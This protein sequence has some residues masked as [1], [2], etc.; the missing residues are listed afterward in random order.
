MFFPGICLCVL[1]ESS[2][3][4]VAA[5]AAAR[6][7][8]FDEVV[9]TATRRETS[10]SE[11]PEAVSVVTSEQ[12]AGRQLALDAIADTVGGYVQ[13]TTPGQGAA[14]I[15]GLKGSALLHLVDGMRLNNAIF[16]NAPTQYFALLPTTAAERIEVVRG[17]PASLYGSDA[18]G[19][20]V[21]F[22]TRRPAFESADAGVRGELSAGYE[23]VD[24]ARRIAGTIDAG[25]TDWYLTVSAESLRAGNRT[26]GGGETVGPS[27]WEARAGR[28]AAGL[29]PDDETTWSVDFH[30]YEQPNTPRVDELVPGSGQEDPSSSEFFFAPNRRVYGKA[31]Y[32]KSNGLAGVDWDVS[33][34]WQHIDDDRVT[35]DF[36]APDRRREQNSSDLYGLLVTA[37]GASETASW[38]AG[39]EL[40]YDLVTSARQ[41][42]NV[43][44]GA[45]APVTSRFPDGSEVLRGS[46]FAS[47]E[48]FVGER[49]TLSGGLRFSEVDVRLPATPVTAATT[50][51]NGDLAGDL[52]AIVDLISGWQWTANLGA[53]FRAPNVFDLGTLGSRPGNRFNVPNTFL[54]SEQV[55]QFDTGLRYL[56]DRLQFEGVVY[57]LRYDDRITS[58]LTGQTT[59]GGRDIVQ[60]VNATRSSVHGAELGTI[61]RLSDAVSLRAVLTW[62]RGEQR[63]AGGEDEPA[64]RIP[65]LG[66]VVEVSYDDGGS[67]LFDGW[68]RYAAAQDRLSARDIR[69]TR[70]NPAGTPGWGSLGVRAR[71]VPSERWTISVAL[72]NL[73]DKRYRVHAS[74]IDAPGRNLA[75]AV[76]LGF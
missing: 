27:G 54:D 72:D 34:A 3:L 53:G 32:E 58:V 69:D 8:R 13:Q 36:E 43:A 46:I 51:R 73:L 64:D 67:W 9:V 22:V 10:S 45:T 29:T 16:R 42:E 4:A 1:A 49:L 63:V 55:L 28:F 50:I 7:D 25:S 38:L 12:M 20:V 30:Y 71:F 15:R 35:R 31:R 44:S 65:P 61:V 17:T 75:L 62:T 59:P 70:I 24:D 56:S 11:I 66:G 48:R 39:V 23:T 47:M 2:A 57:A 18:V 41:V 14:I 60:S 26:V 76:S 74:G 21:Q 68:L 19:G 40:Y 5:P 37:G 52:G 33:F 6:G